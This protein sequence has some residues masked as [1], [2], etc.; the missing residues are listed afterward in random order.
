MSS[1]LVSASWLHANLDSSRSNVKVLDCS[2]HLPTAN[3]SART[4]YAKS[5]IPGAQFFDIDTVKDL[6]KGDLPH[7]L[8]PA[9]FFGTSMDRYGITGSDHVVLY[10]TWGVGPACRVLWTFHAMGHDK[11]SVLNGGLAAWTREGYAVAK[12]ESSESQV[13][14]QPVYH[15]HDDPLLVCSYVD[16]VGNIEQLKSGKSDVKQIVDARPHS[17]FTGEAPEPR[18]G[19]SSGHMP[20]SVSVPATEMTTVVEGVQVLK[21]PEEIRKVFE[22]RG[23]DL[24]RPIIT[25]CGSG[26]TAAILYFALL[27]AGVPR[28]LLTLYDGSWTEYALNPHSE[29]IKD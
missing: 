5:H 29:I 7:M 21:S 6:S 19:L 22:D 2:W 17:R 23:V 28:E 8:P 27:N 3:R 1:S 4:E 14:G 12:G 13:G 18:A 15:P 20:H 24:S 10:D 25:S 16:V 26:V 9:S 11:V